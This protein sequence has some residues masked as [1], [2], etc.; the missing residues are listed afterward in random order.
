M[1]G[2]GRGRVL[3]S[4]GDFEFGGL[5]TSQADYS[6]LGSDPQADAPGLECVEEHSW[7]YWGLGIPDF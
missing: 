3:S 1:L 4:L 6:Q 5:V 2:L 7:A